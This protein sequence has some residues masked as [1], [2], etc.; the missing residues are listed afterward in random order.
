MN[1]QRFLRNLLFYCWVFWLK[2]I[3]K[4]AKQDKKTTLLSI[5]RWIVKHW[6]SNFLKN[7]ITWKVLWVLEPGSLK[8]LSWG[9]ARSLS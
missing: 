3:K 4:L 9:V 6:S 2:M 7:W 1:I 8:K 5:S